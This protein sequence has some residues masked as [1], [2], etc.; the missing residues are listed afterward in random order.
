[1]AAKK[2][3]K[4]NSL[5][6]KDMRIKLTFIDEILGSESSDPEIQAKFISSKG[7]DAKSLEEEVAAVG[8]DEVIEKS[9]TVFYKDKDGDPFLMPYQIRGYLKATAQ[10]YNRISYKITAGITAFVK[11][12]TTQIYAQ[13]VDG[14]PDKIYFQYDG[15]IGSCQ[16]PLRGST[17]QGETVA[18]ANSESIRAGSFVELNLHLEDGRYEPW[19]KELL[20]HGH[21]SGLGQW[22]NAGKGRFEV[23]YWDEREQKYLPEGYW[24]IKKAKILGKDKEYEAW[25]W[26]PEPTSK[27]K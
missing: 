4:Q 9:K 21:Y 17:P 19:M 11:I 10:G 22:R 5:Q 27:K 2:T 14:D 16:R 18:L 12:L 24:G 20:A 7:P 13:G 25:I 15:N 23:Q 26:G 1:M 8:A 6:P 3:E